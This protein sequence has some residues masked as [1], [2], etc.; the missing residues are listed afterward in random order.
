VTGAEG[1]AQGQGTSWLNT[2]FANLGNWGADIGI[3]LLGV[4]FIGGAIWF[5]MRQSSNAQPA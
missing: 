3:G 2:I 1:A 5:F 4:V